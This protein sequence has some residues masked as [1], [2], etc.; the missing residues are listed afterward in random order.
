MAIIEDIAIAALIGDIASITVVA[1][2]RRRY[3]H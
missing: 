1:T 2:T 3:K